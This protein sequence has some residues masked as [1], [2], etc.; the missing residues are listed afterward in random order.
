MSSHPLAISIVAVFITISFQREFLEAAPPWNDYLTSEVE[1]LTIQT[2]QDI[3]SITPQNWE[4]KRALWRSELQDMLGLAPWPEKSD[5]AAKVERKIEREGVVIENLHFQSRPGLYVAANLYLPKEPPP[6]SGWP[7]VLYV[8]GHANLLDQG[9][10]LGNKTGYQ[11]HGLWLARHGVACLMIDTIQLGELHGEHHG[12][13]KLGRWDWISRGYTPAGVETWSSIRAI[14]LLLSRSEIDGSRIGITGRSGGGA[15]SWFAAALDERIRV[16]VPVAGITDL[17][18]HVVDGC[19]EGHCDCMYFVNYHEWD[20]PKL[21]ALIAPLPLLLT[22][23]DSDGIFPLDGVMRTHRQLAALYKRLG[24]SDNYGV[25]IGPGPHKDIQEL[26]VGAFRWLIRHLT[27]KEVTVDSAALKELEPKELATFPHET[28]ADERV[29]SVAN[30]FVDAASSLDDQVIAKQSWDIEWRKVFQKKWL[31]SDSKIDSQAKTRFEGNTPTHRWR[32]QELKIHPDWNPLWLEIEPSQTSDA[33]STIV[34]VGLWKDILIHDADAIENQVSQGSIAEAIQSNADHRHCFLFP[35]GW[36]CSTWSTDP[37]KLTQIHRR[38]YLIGQSVEGLQ[39]QDCH[40]LLQW[41]SGSKTSTSGEIALIGYDRVAPLAVILGLESRSQQASIRPIASLRVRDYPNDPRF[42]PCLLGILRTCDFSSL[43]VAAKGTLPVEERNSSEQKK[44]QLL[45]ETSQQPQQCTGIR[46]VE[47]GPN[48][49]TIWSRATRWSLPNLSDLAAV[50]FKSDSNKKAKQNSGA[51]LPDDGVDGL[52]HAA[53]GVEAEMRIRFRESNSGTWNSTNWKVVDLG[54]DFSMLTRLT[55][56]QANKTYEVRVEARAL[57]GTDPSSTVAGQFKTLPDP[58]S[59]TD[60]RIAIGTCQEF[61]DRDGPHG[62]DVYRTML[63]RKTDAFFM[64]GD[65]VYYDQLARSVPLANYH[66]QRTY[67]LPTL[68]HFH[69]QVPTFFLKDDHD[70]YV[71]DSWPNQKFPWTD[72]FTFE[73]G[74]RIFKQQTGLPDPAYRTVKMGKDLQIWLLEGRD[75]RS[76]NDLLDSPEKSILGSEQKAW[77]QKTL[78]ESKAK[79]RVILSPTPIVGPD[80]ENKH[81]N[82]SNSNFETEGK[83]IR[84]LLSKWPNTFVVCGDRHWQYHS[85]DPE[86]KLHEFSV[87]PV[88]NRHAGGWNQKDF[89]KDYHQYLRVE[90][91]YL[92]LQ[93]NA[94]QGNTSLTAIHLDPYGQEHHRHEW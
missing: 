84:I 75:Y 3:A 14:D 8:C 66:W 18:N 16:A 53:P 30:W 33:T 58:N 78:G 67:S 31:Q 94:N 41:M 6:K 13:Y 1:R 49:A 37:K 48:T 40:R 2:S 83:Q 4:M 47:V 81:D 68:V 9:R 50:R 10:L 51:I 46:I 79:Y 22:N 45:V 87:G 82:L 20:Y 56:L 27:E 32:L 39:L 61:E 23:T 15:Y 74:Q 29:T 54:T 71:N 92:E 24:K 91:G 5:L 35:R 57:R 21:A 90:G 59:A 63:D 88:S 17:E 43:L 89:R 7:A 11:H 62:F 25:L 85:I 80:R 34:H 44:T 77:L 86:T 60:I 26:Q 72:S 19:V 93:L 42:S 65:V 69:R 73:D 12:T 52:R 64:A 36:D 70:T 28:P 76:P 55:D 38:F